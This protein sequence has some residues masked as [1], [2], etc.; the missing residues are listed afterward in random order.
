[1]RSAPSGSG[2]ASGSAVETRPQAGLSH[3]LEHM[4]FR[5]APGYTSLEIDQLFDEMGAEVNA[6]TGQETTSVYS[7]VLDVHLERAFD[8]DGRHGPAA[9]RERRARVRAPDRPRGDRDVRGRSRTRR[10]STCSA[11]RSSA[12]TRSA[13]RS[14]AGPRRSS[15]APGDAARLPRRA[16]RAGNIVVAA[17]G[18]VDHD[19]LVELV[20]RREPPAGQWAPAGSPRAAPTSR[21]RVALHG[22][23]PSSTTSASARRGSRATT[24]VASR[25]V[26]CDTILG[27]SG[28]SRP[29]RRSVRSAALP[30]RLLVHLAV[31]GDRSGRRTSRRGARM[32]A[33]GGRDRRRARRAF[34]AS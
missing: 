10:S 20:G 34:R 17:A 19:R 30:T 15:A 27:G 8:V 26:C 7:R 11:R 33:S 22:R 28:S 13:A 2:S 21:R 23:R 9:A 1:M 12:T 24:S 32:L 16:L 14:S 29:F 25:C 5:G 3:L 18:S 31:R 4:L 6:G